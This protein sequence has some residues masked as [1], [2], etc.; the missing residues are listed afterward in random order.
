MKMTYQLV[1]ESGSFGAPYGQDVEHGSKKDAESLLSYWVNQHDRVGSDSAMASIYA[2]V[3]HY[4][5]VTDMC[6]DYEIKRGPHDGTVWG[7]V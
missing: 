6:P 5:D 2:Y 7:R 1:S 3:G 4:D